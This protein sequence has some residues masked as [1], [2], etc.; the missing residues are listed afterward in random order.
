MIRLFFI[1]SILCSC[2]INESYQGK[3]I[4][5]LVID[6]KLKKLLQEDINYYSNNYKEYYGD[7]IFTLILDKKNDINHLRF[8]ATSGIIDTFQYVGYFYFNNVLFL[9]RDTGV[10]EENSLTLVTKSD[11]FKIFSTITLKSRSKV[12]N[13][14]AIYFIHYIYKDNNLYRALN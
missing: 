6:E 7:S 3:K 8:Y 13:P 9:F 14:D 2:S 4:R 1:I 11:D 10:N 5:K 12:P